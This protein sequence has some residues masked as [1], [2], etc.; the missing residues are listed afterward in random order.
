M[1]MRVAE[2][3]ARL[4]TQSAA[5]EAKALPLRSG[6]PGDETLSQGIDTVDEAKP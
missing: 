3:P 2:R 6:P 5:S 1:K 4:I